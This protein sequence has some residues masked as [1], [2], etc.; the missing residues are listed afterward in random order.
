MSTFKPMLVFCSLWLFA[1]KTSTPPQPPPGPPELP[2]LA[3]LDV[4]TP[5]NAPVPVSDYFAHSFGLFRGVLWDFDQARK[6]TVAGTYPEWRWTIQFGGWDLLIH[7]EAGS[8]NWFNWKEIVD[9][10]EEG[11]MPWQRWSGAI[12]ADGLEGALAFYALDSRNETINLNWSL[13]A[14]GILQFVSRTTEFASAAISPAITEVTT[15]PADS[16]KMIIKTPDTRVMIFAAFWD[17]T[18]AGEWTSYN[19]ITGQ[20]KDNGDW[21]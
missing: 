11:R 13:D 14:P 16:V 3:P 1:C 20:P 2:A 5:R 7:A 10:N 19:A 17:S 8:E 15:T 4:P 21:K 18:G 6:V 12:R 9:F